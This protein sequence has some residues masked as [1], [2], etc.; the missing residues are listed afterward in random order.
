MVSIFTRHKVR[1]VA[2]HLVIP[3]FLISALTNAAQSQTTNTTLNQEE[4]LRNLYNRAYQLYSDRPTRDF[5][6]NYLNFSIGTSPF[7]QIETWRLVLECD[8]Q[9]NVVGKILRGGKTLPFVFCVNHV[10][11]TPKV[12]GASESTF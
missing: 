2:W 5:R 1:Q 9:G 12:F 10:S 6:V 8:C 3:I 11:D 4:H 7:G